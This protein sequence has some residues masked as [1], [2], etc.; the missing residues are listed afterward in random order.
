MNMVSAFSPADLAQMLTQKEAFIFDMDGVLINTSGV[1]ERAYKQALEKLAEKF[2]YKQYMGMSTSDALKTFLLDESTHEFLKAEKQRHALEHS[3]EASI[4]SHVKDLLVLLRRHGKK[5]AVATS[6]SRERAFMQLRAHGIEEY[7]Q[8]IITANEIKTAKPAPD[9]YRAALEALGSSAE[10]TI[11]IEDALSGVQAALSAG[12]EPIAV[13]HTHAAS[14]LGNDVR[15]IQDMHSLYALL[16]YGFVQKK[17][18]LPNNFPKRRVGVIL[19]VAGKG[20][21]LSFDKPKILYPIGSTRALDIM[22]RKVEALAEGIHFITSVDGENPIR[23]ALKEREFF[24]DITVDPEPYGTAGSI[25][26]TLDKVKH[27]KD[28]L[29]IWGDQIGISREALCNIICLH[30]INDADLSV[31]VILRENPYIHF[32]RDSLGIIRDVLR[33]AFNDP[34]PH[35]GENDSGVF[36]IKGYLLHSVLSSMKDEYLKRHNLQSKK[37][38][39]DEEFDFLD[40]IP[41][42]AAQGKVLTF[43]CISPEET[44]GYNTIDEAKFHEERIMSGRYNRYY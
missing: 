19:P 38:E 31:P 3:E 5:L 24:A 16:A 18:A 33:K 27:Y 41:V 17:Y 44:V 8:A 4:Y 22:Y 34:M 9:L 26:L 6:A 7:F 43:P 23:D 28:I 15:T 20:K 11:V 25:A 40:I 39:R 35:Y 32:E 29:I 2:N 42:I 12:I 37:P 21:R 10:K 1:H 36:V 14:E 30:Q 13:L